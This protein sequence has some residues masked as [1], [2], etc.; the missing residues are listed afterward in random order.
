M[1]PKPASA[2]TPAVERQTLPQALADVLKSTGRPM[3]VQ[4]LADELLRRK[5][6][7]NS[8]NLAKMISNKVSEYVKKGLLAH[9]K[10]RGSYI[11]AQGKAHS[12]T[13]P[14]KAATARNGKA[15][16]GHASRNGSQ[17]KPVAG[18]GQPSLRSLLVVLLSKSKQPVKAK[19]LATQVLATG[20]KTT[21]KNFINVIWVS[22]A[23]MDNVENVPDQG[24]RLKKSAT[25]KK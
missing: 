16:N 11:L 13:K 4:E 3:T 8:Q 19:D 18:K 9:A 10:D 20:Y 15:S 2:P 14:A 22:L 21:S 25:K 12:T 5:F 1:Q 6:P 7:T 24:F 23:A 17:P